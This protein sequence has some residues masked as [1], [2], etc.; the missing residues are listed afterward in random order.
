LID[1]FSL[2]WVD[3]KC[4]KFIHK[5]KRKN[6][7][8]EIEWISRRLFNIVFIFARYIY[9]ARVKDMWCRPI[10][11]CKKKIV[12]CFLIQ[13][14]CVACW[15]ISYIIMNILDE[16]FKFQFHN[17]SL[18]NH[19]SMES[20]TYLQIRFKF[21][22][23]FWDCTHKKELSNRSERVKRRKKKNNHNVEE[24]KKNYI[25]IIFFKKTFFYAYRDWVT[26]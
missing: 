7:I 21:K 10:A 1:T 6:W 22:A 13:H 2:N 11:Y 16:N 12:D 23:C 17:L 15:I 20:F 25:N 4:H 19:F 26:S 3:L 18:T 14:L 8:F 24:V 9:F 5:K